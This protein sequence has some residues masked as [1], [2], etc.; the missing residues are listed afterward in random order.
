MLI[1]IDASRATASERTGTENYSLYLIRAL[2]EQG[3]EHRFRL[4]F[5]QPPT[6]ELFPRSERVEWRV[7][8]FPRLWTH[9]RLAWELQQHPP[10]VLF[11]PSH[12]LPLVHPPRCVATVHDLGYR[13]YPQAHTLRS[14]W[15][16]D[17]STRRDARIARRV[18]A[19]SEAT[20]LDLA[21]FYGIDPA[22]VVVAYPAGGEGF[23]PVRD[24][25]TLARVRQRYGTGA[26]YFLYVGTLQPRKNL[27]TLLI[28]F[29][30]LLRD[31]VLTDDVRLVMAGKKGWLYDNVLATVRALALEERVVFTGYV[32]QQDLPTL[33]SGALAYV[34]PSWYEGFGLPV[35]EAM[36]CETP[37]IC[38]N[39]SSLPEVAG[40]AALLFSPDD[41]TAL[42]GAMERVYREPALRN[43][44]AARGREQARCFSW[45]RCAQQVLA[46][47]ESAAK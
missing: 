10:D 1:G 6:E 41:A 40:D 30:T 2:L 14:R 15:Y 19:D 11:V 4:Y 34:L 16:L 22:K 44:L 45:E 47:L 8:P 43:E 46:A 3:K 38:S 17:W 25:A 33:L 13:H 24:A 29:A 27:P 21:T 39:V 12:V 5:N 9:V 35:L 28:A 31:G 37:V 20:R 18:I 32:P 42:A 36:A 23:A 7:I 26:S